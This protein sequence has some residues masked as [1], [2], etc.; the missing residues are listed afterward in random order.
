MDGNQYKEVVNLE[1]KS[2]L[3]AGALDK[4]NLKNPQSEFPEKK[5]KH[6]YEYQELG[7]E[8]E[9][10]YGKRIW[11]LFYRVGFTEY[12]IRKAHEQCL[13]YKKTNIGYLITVIKNQ[14]F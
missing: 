3:F 1:F 2:N 4:Y 7:T 9:P 12:K 5:T 13:K 11:Q 14:K 10:Y 6:K 8:L